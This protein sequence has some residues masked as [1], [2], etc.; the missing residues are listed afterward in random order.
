MFSLHVFTKNTRSL[1]VTRKRRQR[2]RDRKCHSQLLSSA[3]L[4]EYDTEM[5]LVNPGRYHHQ[6]HNHHHQN[7][8][9][10]HHHHHHHPHHYPHPHRG[11]RKQGTTTTSTT[12]SSQTP[13]AHVQSSASK[14]TPMSPTLLLVDTAKSRGVD[15]RLK[16]SGFSDNNPNDDLANL[17]YTNNTNERNITT[18]NN[19]TNTNTISTYN[20]NNSSVAMTH[21][22]KQKSFWKHSYTDSGND[23]DV[24]S[25]ND[26]YLRLPPRP[27]EEEEVFKQCVDHELADDYFKRAL[28]K[29]AW[30][31]RPSM[32]KLQLRR[33]WSIEDV[34]LLQNLGL[35]KDV[36]KP[37]KET[38]V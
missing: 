10:Y 22:L 36:S 26:V 7:Y 20:K 18:S 1:A 3:D 29:N 33:T 23:S 4:E 25:P 21:L 9:I 31:V 6:N 30:E 5:G 37:N 17:G 19:N 32:K 28:R 15:S 27:C 24:V 12:A 38:C 8:D 35:H 11:S 16:T 14:S 34:C 2:M 13:P